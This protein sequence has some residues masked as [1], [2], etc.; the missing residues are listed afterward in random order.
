MI[1]LLQMYLPYSLQYQ[2][3]Y[4]SEQI[5][6]EPQ[7]SSYCKWYTKCL[8]HGYQQRGLWST[9]S[10]HCCCFHMMIR[11]LSMS[12]CCQ[13]LISWRFPW[14]TCSPVN[15]CLHIL[16]HHYIIITLLLTDLA[17]FSWRCQL[18]ANFGATVCEVSLGFS[19]HR[20]EFWSGLRHPVMISLHTCVITYPVQAHMWPG[21]QK[22][23]MWVPI[24]SSL[25]LVS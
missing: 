17:L 20:S 6:N 11:Q 19:D 21:M 25:L 24:F 15:T 4:K 23:T 18:L 10:C 1:S 13:R 16:H 22:S 12:Y 9:L 7:K 8:D 2:W 14:T 5:R 3:S